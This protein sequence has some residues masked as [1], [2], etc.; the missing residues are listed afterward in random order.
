MLKSPLNLSIKLYKFMRIVSLIISIIAIFTVIVQRITSFIDP[1]NPLPN[2]AISTFLGAGLLYL[3]S[4][5]IKSLI[6]GLE[7]EDS[8]VIN[9]CIILSLLSSLVFIFL[10]FNLIIIAQLVSYKYKRGNSTI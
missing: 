8:K 10:P 9:Y 4:R 3:Y 7:R 6:P 2:N 5:A 1:T